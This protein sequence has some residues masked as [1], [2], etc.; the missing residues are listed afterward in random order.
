LLK[1]LIYS[2][3]NNTYSSRKIEKANK[4]NIYYHWLNGQNFPDHLTI[5]NFRGKR[6]KGIIDNIF[7]QVVIFI[8]PEQYSIVRRVFT[9]VQK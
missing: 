5:N 8:E 9:D 4:E 3:L 7:A 6:L 2:Y 1:I